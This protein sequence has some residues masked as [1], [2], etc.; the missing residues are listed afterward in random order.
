MTLAVEVVE[1]FASPQQKTIACKVIV[2]I[3]H[4]S[5][6]QL[7]GNRT[8]SYPCLVGEKAHGA[9]YIVIIAHCL[10]AFA[11]LMPGVN[12]GGAWRRGT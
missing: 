7:M 12:A 8:I 10:A 3:G 6:S 1:P 2:P 9:S 11:V 4:R 5:S